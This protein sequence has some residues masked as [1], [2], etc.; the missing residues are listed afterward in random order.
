M[1]EQAYVD[2]T[3][4]EDF[5]VHLKGFAATTDKAT[6]RLLTALSGL[7]R[8][9]E[10]QAFEQFQQSVR[11]LAQTLLTFVGDAEGFSAYLTTKAVEAKAIH[12]MNHP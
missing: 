10:D 4:L 3:K 9:W 8:S 1:S 12:Q 2:P 7:S 5:A 11:G 6:D